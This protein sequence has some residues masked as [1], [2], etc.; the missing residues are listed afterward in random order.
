MNELS[1]GVEDVSSPLD[2]AYDAPKVVVKQDYSCRLLGYVGTLVIVII[3]FIFI[4]LL[5][6]KLL[7]II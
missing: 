6:F 4:I 2:G 5:L 7:I 1:D 3:Y